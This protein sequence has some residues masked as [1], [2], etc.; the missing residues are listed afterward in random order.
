MGQSQEEALKVV[1]DILHCLRDHGPL[2]MPELTAKL[3]QHPVYTILQ[4]A[5]DLRREGRVLHDES[6]KIWKVP[7]LRLV[8]LKEA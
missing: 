2:T 3:L 1:E 8:L 6:T 7:G 5:K 4:T